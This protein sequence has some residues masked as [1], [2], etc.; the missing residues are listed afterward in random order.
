MGAIGSIGAAWDRSKAKAGAP[1]GVR[2]AIGGVTIMAAQENGE[3]Q[4]RNKDDAAWGIVKF[5]SWFERE[6]T[7]LDGLKMVGIIT[8]QYGPIPHG[9]MNFA[10]NDNFFQ[11]LEEHEALRNMAN[12]ILAASNAAGDNGVLSVS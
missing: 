5:F 12:L 6:I 9:A 4:R 3:E 7:F 11:L 1:R 2:E 10:Y 8:R